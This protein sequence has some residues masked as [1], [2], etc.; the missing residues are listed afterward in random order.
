MMETFLGEIAEQLLNDYGTDLRRICLVFPNR[1]AAQFM[2]KHLALKNNR[3]PIWAPR[4]QTSTEL[5]RGYSTLIPAER[6]L[7]L[8]ELYKVHQRVTGRE[9]P[10][11]QFI[12]W[13]EIL[14]SDFN[15]IDTWMIPAR[16]L[17]TNLAAEKELLLD[18]DYLS[19]K[20]VQAIQLFWGEFS[21]DNTRARRDFFE[22][23]EKL[24][25]IYEEFRKVLRNQGI[26]YEGM[27]YR[28]AAASLSQNWRSEG[29]DRYVCIGFNQLDACERELFHTLRHKEK[30]SFY[31]DYDK[32][33]VADSSHE[34]G[35][36]ARLN[37]KFILPGQ[38]RSHIAGSTPEVQVIGVPM[39]A[40]QAQVIG[41][42]MEQR[43]I[44]PGS[45]AVIMPREELLPSLLSALP[46]SYDRVNVT[47]GYP[48]SYSALYPLC[49]SLYRM[50]RRMR[51]SADTRW[52]YA[53]YTIQVLQN[54]Y[55]QGAL[56]AGTNTAI[57]NWKATNRLYLKDEELLT[58][59]GEIGHALFAPDQEDFF[60]HLLHILETMQELL[61]DEMPDID[62]QLLPVV[63]KELRRLHEILASEN[64]QAGAD[65]QYLVI[66]ATLRSLKVPF[67]GEP[68]EGLQ[69]LGPLE[70]RSLDFEHVF[71]PCMNEGSMP[72]DGGSNTYIPFTLRKAFGLPGPDEKTAAQ[73]YF[74][75]RLLHRA[76]HVYLLY[77]TESE[78]ISG[79]EK[80]RYLWQI[81]NE[82]TH[83]NIRET[84][85]GNRFVPPGERLLQIPKTGPVWDTMQAFSRDR[86]LSPSAISIYLDCSLKFYLSKIAWLQEEDEIDDDVDHALFGNILHATLENLYKPLRNR[87]IQDTDIQNLQQRL[88]GELDQAFAA[89]FGQGHIYSAESDKLI[90][91]ELLADYIQKVLDNDRQRTPFTLLGTEIGSEKED[92]QVLPLNIKAG[93]EELQIR[94]AGKIDRVDMYRGTIQVID[95]KT[96]MVDLRFSDL[97]GLFD[98][99]TAG[100]YKAALQTL[101]YGFM[102]RYHTDK[103]QPIQPGIY[104]LKSGQNED[105]LLHLSPGR[106]P[107][108][109]IAELEGE[110]M[111]RLSILLQEIYNPD[112]PFR[113]TED[114][115]KCSFCPFI[116]LCHRDIV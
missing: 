99:R 66:T 11:H 100:R 83:W 51:R 15:E 40:G 44:D 9:E 62:K 19:E 103:T 45:A 35:H 18:M 59:T 2:Y 88:S 16:L 27:I 64:S 87:V 80:S 84:L 33:Y 39:E 67:L 46:A 112:L 91:R 34:A 114:R 25:L 61:P 37:Q 104:A 23:W 28:D 90:I 38:I 86:T 7:L 85:L 32:H 30:V 116:Q 29:F 36:F 82:I 93:G 4:V 74:F 41:Q 43:G 79:G 6:L 108:H 106:I 76:R 101:L 75:Y 52:F 92:R 49:E 69:V 50:Y 105:T 57:E 58:L 3:Q 89:A 72:G 17:Y 13:G 97:E 73:A 102:Y 71:I 5:L 115:S 113:Q 95:Y 55:I 56:P 20:Q 60:R 96:G 110:F 42:L 65:D 24:Y 77:N 63:Y 54:P 111:S 8:S 14:L 21:K 48:V 12:P 78:G 98:P 26:G 1:R 109:D 94:L 68:V 47:M 53:P 31:W 81:Q 70:S 107:L 10:L 22:I